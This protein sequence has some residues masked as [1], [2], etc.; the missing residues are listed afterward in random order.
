MDPASIQKCPVQ[1]IWKKTHG[2]FKT[3][4]ARIIPD[5]SNTH[6]EFVH[7]P[8]TEDKKDRQENE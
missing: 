8:S 5:F 2:Y 7:Q 3:F 6:I 4:A 1:V